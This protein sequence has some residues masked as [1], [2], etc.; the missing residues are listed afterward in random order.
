MQKRLKTNTVIWFGYKVNWSPGQI[1]QETLSQKY[2]T[3]KRASRVTH[4]A[5]HLPSKHEVLSLHPSA[6]KKKEK[7]EKEI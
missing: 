3:Q 6:A 5:E 1:I 4:V 2:P 7:E